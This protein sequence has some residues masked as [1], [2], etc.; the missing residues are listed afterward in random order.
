MKEHRIR[1]ERIA[2]FYENQALNTQHEFSWMAC[3]GYAHT[4]KAI[5]SAFEVLNPSVHHV[6]AP[7]GLSRFYRKGFY[8]EV[9]S[10][11]M[12]KALRE[13]EIQDYTQFLDQAYAN[14]HPDTLANDRV[15]VAFGFSQGCATASRW[16]CHTNVPIQHLVLW[17]G[18]LAH[19]IPL[20]RLHFFLDRAEI[21]IVMGDQDPFINA[22]HI[23]QQKADFTAKNIAVTFHHFEGGHVVDGD[24]LKLLATHLR[25]G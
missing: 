13:E 20:E 11:W 16:A 15:N 5:Q 10:S 24:A 9:V 3:H 4:A 6:V 2:R 8:G 18:T 14:T 21:H 22:E 17:G 7:E 23:A 19:D 12:T 1:I 25:K